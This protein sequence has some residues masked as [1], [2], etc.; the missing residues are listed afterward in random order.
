MDEPLADTL[1]EIQDGGRRAK[2][3]WLCGW[4]TI[5][6]QINGVGPIFQ[7]QLKD[8]RSPKLIIE[9]NGPRGASWGV[10]LRM[11]QRDQKLPPIIVVPGTSG[12]AI[13]DVEVA[14]DELELLRQRYSGNS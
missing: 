6:A 12:T 10:I 1:Y 11:T 7:V 9:D 2:A 5:P 3:A 13:A 8:F 14:K 4:E